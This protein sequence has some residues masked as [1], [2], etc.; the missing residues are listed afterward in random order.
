MKY[1]LIDGN[2]LA[3]RSAFANQELSNAEG[4]PTGV[5]FGVF[6]SL[7]NLKRAY[8]SHRFL[9]VWDGKSKRRMKEAS[10][11]VEKKL[12]PS[13]YKANRKKDDQPKPLLDFYAQAP[14]LKKGIDKAGIPQIRLAD[15]EADDVIAS[16]CRQL[17]ADEI[18]VVTSDKDYFQLLDDKVSIWN[19]MTME[20]IDKD[21]FKEKYEIEPL[22]FVDCGALSGDTSDNI[23][24][25]PSWGEKT[26]ISMIKTHKTWENMYKWLHEEY[27]E[28]REQFPDLS[29][30][31]FKQLV[32]I[33]TQKGNQKYPEIDVS[34]PF[35]GVA[36]AV[37]Q[38]KTKNIKKNILL[39]LMFEERVRLAY[40]LKK[41]DDD[42]DGL[43]EISTTE[44]NAEKLKE[45]LDY[46]DIESLT[47][48]IGMFKTG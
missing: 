10:V 37:E 7:L 30:E 19:G 47:D 24:G 11:G 5:H 25:I 21:T 33:K 20:K 15:Y 40:S 1:L 2:N 9:M 27:D 48:E 22:Q 35:T 3:I 32:G 44:Y 14:Y 23:F 29:E 4:I 43:P 45:Y 38:K 42:I 12:I 16:Y 41:M 18:V 31:D 13:G 28:R 46:Y 26:S 34:M 36:L 6:Q 39:A 8:P 17:E